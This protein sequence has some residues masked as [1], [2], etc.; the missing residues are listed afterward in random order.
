MPHQHYD[1]K[2]GAL[3]FT[4]TI[5]EKKDIE[6]KQ[7]VRHLLAEVEDLKKMVEILEKD[8]DILKENRIY[9]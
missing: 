1:P 7:L 3:I 8:I 9:G 6:Y 4:P 5:S 2:S